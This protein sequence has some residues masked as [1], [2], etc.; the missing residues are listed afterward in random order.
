MVETRPS[1]L[2]RRRSQ[3]Q[4]PRDESS[5]HQYVVLVSK[6]FV[7]L[8]VLSSILVAFAVG[9]TA[10][11][12]LLEDSR[13]GVVISNAAPLAA[14]AEPLKKMASLPDPVLKAG[15]TAQPTQYTSKT[16]DTTMSASSQ[17]RWIV[18]KDGREK[19][20]NLSSHD[21]ECEY[22]RVFSPDMTTRTCDG[23]KEE[24]DNDSGKEQIHL[25]AGQHLLMDIENVNKEFLDSEERLANAML[26][27]LDNCDLTLLSYHCHKLEPS[28]VSCA[29]VLLESH[30]SFHTWPASGVITLDLFTCGPN[31]LL[32]IVPLAEQLFAVPSSD[33]GSQPKII[34]AHKIRGF[35]D[36]GTMDVS[37]STDMQLF[38]IGMMTEY[39]KE[40]RR[41]VK[42]QYRRAVVAIRPCKV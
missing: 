23:D 14:L 41:V 40:V 1:S 27:L 42:K 34:W 15:K 19:C 24:C 35:S 25:P 5:K 20:V 33:G 32:P 21:G 37:E 30:V 28:G 26:E 4:R 9:R 16:F 10:R 6:G 12:L 8:S 11:V 7:I 22:D 31:S 38:P 17:S 3:Q 29:G 18:T 39:K 13:A 2:D 36:S